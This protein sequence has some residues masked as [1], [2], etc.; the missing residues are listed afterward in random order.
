MY[1]QRQQQY[2]TVLPGGVYT[3]EMIVN[4]QDAFVGSEAGT[5]RQAI[6]HFLS[7]TPENKI[8]FNL[9]Q[10]GNDLKINYVCTHLSDRSVINFAL[11]E[12]G[13]T[14]HVH[15]GENEGRTLAHDNVVREFKTIAFDDNQGTI[16]IPK[17][18]EKDL[19]R[20]SVIAFIQSKDNM[21]I[22]AATKVDLK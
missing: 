4:G 14:S 15:A 1:T 13:L 9:D 7:L 21:V 16:V 10:S 20:F 6:E 12:R 22:A 19:T 5:A 17:P 3:P 8:S 11:V 2:A 18:Q